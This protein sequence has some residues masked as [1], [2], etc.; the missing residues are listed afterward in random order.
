MH[1]G[2]L[3][4]E[5][6]LMATLPGPA[7]R[8]AIRRRARVSRERVADELGVQPLAVARWE[9]GTREPRGEL[10]LRYARLLRML[11]GIVTSAQL[12]SA[13]AS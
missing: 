9:R 12:G 5:V 1:M 6:Q 8:M 10:R 13:D 3:A 4:D 7:E 11:D 2:T